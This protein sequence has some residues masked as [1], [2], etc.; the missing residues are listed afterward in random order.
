MILY[1]SSIIDLVIESINYSL[2]VSYLNSPIDFTW[3]SVTWHAI[4][5]VIWDSIRNH[6][7]FLTAWAIVDSYIIKNTLKV[8]WINLSFSPVPVSHAFM[9]DYDKRNKNELDKC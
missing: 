3:I 6:D 8:I 5:I 7:P 1:S 4:N 9:W 2:L